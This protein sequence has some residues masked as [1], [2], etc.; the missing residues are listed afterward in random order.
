MNTRQRLVLRARTPAQE[1]RRLLDEV[2][3]SERLGREV[4]KESVARATDHI[5]GRFDTWLRIQ[6]VPGMDALAAVVTHDSANYPEMPHAVLVAFAAEIVR[7]HL[8]RASA[9]VAV[10]SIR[11]GLRAQGWSLPGLEAGLRTKSA[12]AEVLTRIISTCVIDHVP[13]QPVMPGQGLESIAREL[14]RLQDPLLRQA[15]LTFHSLAFWS[16]ARITEAIGLLTWS[17]LDQSLTTITFPAGLK[18]QRE[19]VTLP[20]AD[21]SSIEPLACARTQLEAWR[22]ICLGAGLPCGADDAVFPG[23]TAPTQSRLGESGLTWVSNPVEAR[24]ADGQWRPD[25]TDP[26]TR[27]AYARSHVVASYR[28][29]W[30]A[31]ARRAEFVVIAGRRLSPHG[32]RRGLATA[33]DTAGIDIVA[34]SVTLRHNT[35]IVTFRYIDGSEMDL[36]AISDLIDVT[37]GLHGYDVPSGDDFE[38]LLE[39]PLTPASSEMTDDGRCVVEDLTGERCTHKAHCFLKEVGLVCAT[40]YGRALRIGTGSAAFRRPTTFTDSDGDGAIP[41]LD[42]EVRGESSATLLPG[43]LPL[44][45]LAGCA[46]TSSDGHRCGHVRNTW[47][48]DA[49]DGRSVYCYEHIE[50]FLLGDEAW[51]RPLRSCQVKDTDDRECGRHGDTTVMPITLEDGQRLDACAAHYRRWRQGKRGDEFHAP[52]K[53]KPLPEATCAVAHEGTPCGLPAVFVYDLT[54]GSFSWSQVCKGHGQR[55]INGERGERLTRPI[56]QKPRFLPDDACEVLHAGEA[57]GARDRGLSRMVTD[58]GTIT[59]MCSCHQS[60]Y[61]SG[62]RGER[63]ARPIAGR[64]TA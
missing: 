33:L 24:V 59:I 46:A 31:A 50:R 35:P 19:S 12:V 52:V 20:L 30:I 5:L 34:I 28:A 26:I 44:D 3:D 49:G 18:F 7:P 6:G 41:D 47:S 42:D 40:H 17:W 10:K 15:L 61:K 36:T 56:K 55:W 29:A 4:D 8:T 25:V 2:D 27:R 21:Y 16:G 37:D 54:G 14:D 48:F 63:L 13:A 32:T 22:A 64:H 57:C 51:Q 45:Y 60:R 38:M 39:V 58:D 9:K 53:P 23:F 43:G 11:R 62:D 1:D